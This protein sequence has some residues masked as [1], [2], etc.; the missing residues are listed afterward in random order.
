LRYSVDVADPRE[1]LAAA[2]RRYEK[3]EAAHDDARR[4]V[5][6][7]VVAA[8]KADVPPTEVERL[9]PFSG[10]HIRKLAREHDVPP[11]A[12]GPKRQGAGRG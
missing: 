8:L 5:V 1:R 12:P 7:A 6:D 2:T 3:T 4:A 11:A 9:S 10:A